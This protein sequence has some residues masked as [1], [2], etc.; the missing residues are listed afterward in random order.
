M[1]CI[2]CEKCQTDIYG[3]IN[4]YYSQYGQDIYKDK[5]GD[6]I[7]SWNYTHG[8]FT[9]LKGHI[10]KVRC[11]GVE[12]SNKKCNYHTHYTLE[13]NDISELELTPYQPPSSNNYSNWIKLINGIDIKELETRNWDNYLKVRNGSSTV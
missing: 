3:L 12:C 4:M 13:Y 1:S 2:K 8:N 6:H 5:I 10:G 7:H 11:P 9:C